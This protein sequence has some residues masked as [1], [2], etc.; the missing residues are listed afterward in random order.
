MTED[1]KLPLDVGDVV[2]D[3]YVIERHLG[4]G[5]MGHVFLAREVRLG[6]RV[7]IKI[8]H[9]HV[10][11]SEQGG[12]R[13][14]REAKALSR[15]NHPNV[16]AI[17]RLGPYRDSYFIAME[18]VEG[19]ALDEAIDERGML[20]LEEVVR[21][22]SFVARG[23][24]EAHAVG[25]VHRDIKPGN[26]LLGNQLSG[27]QI[28]KV[29][30]FGLARSYETDEQAQLTAGGN[31]MGTPAYMSPEQIQGHPLDARSDLP[32]GVR[33]YM[34]SAAGQKAP[35]ANKCRNRKPRYEVPDVAVPDAFLSY[36]SGDGL[37]L[38]TNRAKCSGTNS[39]HMVRLNGA[40]NTTELV[41]T[42]RQPFTQLSCE[43][44]GHPLG[45]GML[46]AEPREAGRVVLSR[47][48]IKSKA[49]KALVREG[50]ST[51]RRWRH[52]G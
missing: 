33:R 49:D 46:K 38:V 27:G 34:N 12:E 22:A 28:A 36:M 31:V 10:A 29:V 30:D 48:P 17:Y 19:S 37:A 25:L 26:I 13:F 42:W 2:G 52:C 21:I 7:A 18:Y 20:P 39:V 4:R 35:T 43:L 23:L 44:E 47:K 9:D 5:A 6:R 24:D 11:R 1:D 15:L 50:I 51:M 8:L 3:S 41:A 45:G 16:V 40:M 14:L 32:K